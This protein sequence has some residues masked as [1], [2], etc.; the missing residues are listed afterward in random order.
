M[1]QP[2]NDFIKSA[3]RGFF[4]R[5]RIVFWHD[6]FETLLLSDNYPRFGTALKKPPGL[7]VKEEN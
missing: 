2:G 4:D 7:D 6:V 3:P 5:Y 1:I